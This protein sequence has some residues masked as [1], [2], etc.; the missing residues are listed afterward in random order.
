[1]LFTT[2]ALWWP[3]REAGPYADWQRQGSACLKG[4]T[5]AGLHLEKV[6]GVVRDGVTVSRRLQRAMS[7]YALALSWASLRCFE[8][9][10]SNDLESES[11]PKYYIKCSR[12]SIYSASYLK[13]SQKVENTRKRFLECNWMTVKTRPLILNSSAHSLMAEPR[14]YNGV[15][16]GGLEGHTALWIFFFFFAFVHKMITVILY[17]WAYVM[18]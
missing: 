5:P 17:W 16:V 13:I 11:P 15:G 4:C 3:L 18:L 6:K 14:T 9:F 7:P 12:I 1:M 8:D 10:L 2:T